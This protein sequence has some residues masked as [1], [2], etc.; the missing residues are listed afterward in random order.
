MAG[1]SPEMYAIFAATL[2][3]TALVLNGQLSNLRRFTQLRRDLNELSE[4]MAGVRKEVNDLRNKMHSE[5]AAARDQIA[6]HGERLGRLEGFIR[7]PREVV[8]ESD[9]DVPTY[10]SR[11]KD[12]PDAES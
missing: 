4:Q 5:F 10:L 6:A 3:V 9:T 1:M 7:E 11:G 12:N 2:G 8:R